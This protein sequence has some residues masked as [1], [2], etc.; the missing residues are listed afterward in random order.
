MNGHQTAGRTADSLLDGMTVDE[1]LAQ[2]GGVWYPSLLVDGKVDDGRLAAALADGIGHVS[3]AGAES[4]LGPGELARLVNRVQRFLVEHTRLGIPALFHEEAV[5]GLC[6]PRAAQF[7]QAI[8]L[9]S[10]WDP[11]LVEEVARSTRRHLR[12]VGARVAL[13]PVVDV[14]RDPRWGQLEETYGE[15]PELASR[16]AV[17]CVRGLQGSAPAAG[18]AATAKHFVAHGAPEAGFNQGEVRAGPRYVRD[19][20][21]APFRAAVNEAHLATVMSAYHDLDGLPCS[22]S[23]PI[24]DGLLRDELGFDGVVV[25]DYWAVAQLETVH[26]VVAGPA[27]AAVRALEAGVDVELPALD[28]YRHLRQ[29]VAGG[30]VGEEVVDRAVLRVLRQKE[31]LGLLDDPYVDA[32]AAPAAFDRPE[33]REL[34]RRSAAR[35]MVLLT[36][37]GTLPL[38]P[39]RLGRVLVTGPAADDRRLLLG[40]CNYPARVEGTAPH[41][42][43]EDWVS[44]VTPVAGLRAALPAV[45]VVHVPGP[46]GQVAAAAVAADAAV[47]CVGGRSGV[48][49]DSTSGELRDAA[50]LELP[51]D[52]RRLVAAVAA[53]GTPTV[54]VVV[55]GRAHALV[56]VVGYANA[57]VLAW[58]PGEEGG[59]ALADVLTGRVAPAGRLPVSLLR[60]AG[61]VGVS[62]GHHN[63]GGR[64]QVFGD[65]V[66]EPSGPLFCFG[67]GLGYTTFRYQDLA[68]TPASTDGTV[69]LALTL[70]NSGRR[71]GEEVVQVYA[72]D[73][74][75]SVALPE[76]RLVAFA[77]VG[78]DAGTERRVSF[79]VPAGRLGFTGSDGR[80]VVEPG[81]VTF[82]VG[83]SR[84]DVRLT[85]SVV[86]AGP[87]HFPDRNALPPFS[88][89]AGRQ[90]PASPYS[91]DR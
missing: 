78:V 88:A 57:V 33:D 84:D 26:R 82:R 74:V 76:W 9:A 23:A 43:R 58:L 8:G 63:G 14:A 16:M 18:V 67:H 28:R 90:T 7:P 45:E 17:A 62:S 34:A 21:A 55:S 4:G 56:D 36:N 38:D 27:E 2:L 19:V 79:D 52:Q 32:D 87:A 54:V 41:A 30:A 10:S 35:S 20:A 71:D 29:A 6:A 83:A 40:D 24:L 42:G 64:S 60:T 89:R 65:Y 53:T 77:R 70:A 46:I 31:A 3:T 47:V 91:E 68:V 73:E 66:D 49:R 80:F 61:Q 51:A 37:D 50:H 11:S 44:M 59:S 69:H 15:D 72:H 12:A 48:T 22:G 86:L 1:K 5:A 81:E 85:A 75:A 13:A 39:T 25:S